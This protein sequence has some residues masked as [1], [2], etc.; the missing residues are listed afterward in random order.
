MT[1]IT[2][3]ELEITLEGH[4]QAERIN[5][6]DLVCCA[7]STLTGTLA[8]VLLTAYND[9]KLKE[10]PTLILNDGYACLSCKPRPKHFQATKDIIEAFSVGYKV[11]AEQYPQNVQICRSGG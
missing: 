9:G 11:L 2:I 10:Q 3:G 8:N 5:D 4:A 6:S 1:Y 7:I